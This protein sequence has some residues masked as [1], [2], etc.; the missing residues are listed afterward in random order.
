MIDLC[1]TLLSDGSSDRALIPI[2]NWLLKTHL[3]ECAIQSQWAD[4]RRLDKSLRDTFEKRIQMSVDLYPCDLLFIH[5]DAEKEPHQY[6]VNEI[7]R[8]ISQL[9]DRIPPIVCVVPV[10]MTE[11]WLLFDISA[12]RKAASNPNGKVSLSLP[13]L[14]KIEDE[15]DPKRILNGLLREASELSS[16]RLKKFSE[17]DRVHRLSELIIDFSPL[18]KLPSFLALESE[19]E[20]VIE[21]QKWK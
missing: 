11:A 14:K 12:L 20:C 8:A 13:S 4:L 21:Q 7:Q 2:I 17:S 1:Y 15:P 9:P 3:S 19:I 18:R 6:R 16:Q 5:R 10:R